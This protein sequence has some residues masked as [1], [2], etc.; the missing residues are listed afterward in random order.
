MPPPNTSPPDPKTDY[1][2]PHSHDAPTATLPAAQ[3]TLRLSPHADTMAAVGPSA[4]L[5]TKTYGNPGTTNVVVRTEDDSALP[6]EPS[7]PPRNVRIPPQ[8][9]HSKTALPRSQRLPHHH[10]QQNSGLMA[11]GAPQ[12]TES[13]T[14]DQAEQ[15]QPDP[16]MRYAVMPPAIELPARIDD[17]ISAASSTSKIACSNGVNRGNKVKSVLPAS[18]PSRYLG[19][20][21]VNIPAFSP[22]FMAKSKKHLHK[23]IKASVRRIRQPPESHASAHPLPNTHDTSPCKGA[24]APDQE[25][26]LMQDT[27]EW[28]TVAKP[29]P[30][31]TRS[32]NV[33]VQGHTTNSFA[34]LADMEIDQQEG[35]LITP[36]APKYIPAQQGDSPPTTPANCRKPSCPPIV[37]GTAGS[38]ATPHDSQRPRPQEEEDVGLSLVYFNTLGEDEKKAFFQQ[39]RHS[40]ECHCCNEKGKV[41]LNGK[42]KNGIRA[43][44]KGCGRSHNGVNFARLLLK[45]KDVEPRPTTRGIKR[46]YG[47]PTTTMNLDIEQLVRRVDD[48]E[49]LLTKANE[50]LRHHGEVITAQGLEIAA[51]KEELQQQRRGKMN[52][53]ALQDKVM[54]RRTLSR[55]A[56]PLPTPASPGRSAPA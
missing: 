44:C 14:G 11:P 26:K 27:Q 52:F 39:R 5:Y 18:G 56:T 12:G 8:T 24:E 23:A 34:S 29:A 48:L 49:G 20:G 31:G 1:D 3:A 16:S 53:S 7:H 22:N 30:A 28:T 43:T 10:S 13:A 38:T 2:T 41:Y 19:E 35:G 25:D 47:D 4:H 33:V 42:D 37:I 9:T 6:I 17:A 50:K 21:V 51:L 40:I 54:S 32:K 55:K 15:P 46:R 36:T 45:H